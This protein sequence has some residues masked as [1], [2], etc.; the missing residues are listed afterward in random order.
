MARIQ[1]DLP[2]DLSVL[3]F[4]RQE[5]KEKCKELLSSKVLGNNIF[6]GINPATKLLFITMFLLWLHFI[7]LFL[8]CN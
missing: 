6:F 7:E 4:C 2:M 8:F 1:M 3:Q 5:V